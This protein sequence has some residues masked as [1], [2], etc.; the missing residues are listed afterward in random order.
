MEL[1]P[2][3][4]SSTPTTKIS[5]SLISAIAKQVSFLGSYLRVFLSTRTLSLKNYEICCLFFIY[6]VIGCFYIF[7]IFCDVSWRVLIS[8]YICLVLV[9]PGQDAKDWDIEVLTVVHNGDNDA[10]LT[11]VRK[12]HP[13]EPECI[14]DRRVLGALAP[15]R[16]ESCF[17]CFLF[18]VPFA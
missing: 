7:Y 10:E 16:C 4:P 17:I 12:N 3:S 11:R 1:P 5:G 9:S 13:G 14:V 6:A 8:F 15:T 18:S 2:L